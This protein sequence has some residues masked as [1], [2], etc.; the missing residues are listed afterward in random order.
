MPIFRL[1]E[2][3]IFFPPPFLADPSGIIAVGG[4]L[5]P[6]RLLLAYKMGIFPWYSPEDPP[7]WWCPDP[8]CVVFPEKVNISKSMRQVLRSRKFRV[9]FNRDF[10]GVMEGCRDVFRPGQH[11]TWITDEFIA[12]YHELHERGYVHSV[13]V[14]EEEELV[15]GLYGMVLGKCFFGES[16]F[17]RV[18]NASKTGFI[19]MMRNLEKHNFAVVDCQIRTPHLVSLGAEMIPRSRFLE[20][21]RKNTSN[22]PNTEVNSFS[23][24]FDF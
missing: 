9:T 8:R 3:E 13:E 20:L 17:A 1:E 11:A 14:W 2:D 5:Q 10:L 18:S 21:L 23:D 22:E 24:D 7:V 16:M 4:D 15:G 6:E 19:M 12:S